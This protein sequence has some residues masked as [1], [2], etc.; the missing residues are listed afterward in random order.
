MI[1]AGVVTAQGLMRELQDRGFPCGMA[2]TNRLQEL[3]EDFQRSTQAGVLD[4]DVVRERLGFFEFHPPRALPSAVSMIVVAMPLPKARLVFHRNGRPVVVSVPPAYI[5]FDE[6]GRQ[7]QAMLETILAPAGFHVAP[8]L[9][10][11]KLLAARCGLAAYG[12]NNITFV[13]GMGSFLRLATFFTDVPLED[14]TWNAPEMMP[15][16]AGCHSCARACPT[17][18][19]AP[20]RFLLHTERCVVFHNERP[21]SL[22]LPAWIDPLSHRCLV[23]CLECQKACP[24]NARF[25]D[26]VEDAGE[27][28]QEETAMI[29]GA[30]PQE[31]LPADLIAKLEKSDLLCLFGILS[32]N[33]RAVL[34]AASTA[35]VGP[36]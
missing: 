19:I 3:R 29:T 2:G 26:R 21:G 1:G 15:R 22:P 11:E 33:L 12:R 36:R 4:A 5:G 27:Y 24:E 17:S 8:A 25:L 7:A 18:A 30:I 16:C 20:E 6:A 9:L 10:P 13:P 23:G 28:T 34:D 31:Q 32:R 14:G 35:P